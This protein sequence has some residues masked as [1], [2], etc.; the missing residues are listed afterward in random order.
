MRVLELVD[1]SGDEPVVV[2]D[3]ATLDQKGKVAY[4]GDKVRAIISPF[5][6]DHEP[7]EVFDKMANWSNGY[8]QLQEREQ[9]NASM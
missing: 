5:L 9:S 1:I 2:G 6:I 7:A 3:V 8:V 4:K